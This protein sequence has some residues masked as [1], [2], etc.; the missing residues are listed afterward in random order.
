MTRRRVRTHPYVPDPQELA[1]H[2]GTRRCTT[3]LMPQ[4]H[5]SHTLPDMP[6]AAAED[7]RRLGE[8]ED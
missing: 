2:A 1:D 4:R 7:R 8:S 5:A 3:C 6:E